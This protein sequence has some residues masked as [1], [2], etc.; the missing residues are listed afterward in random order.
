MVKSLPASAGDVRD[1]PGLIP[2]FRRFPKGE[3]GSPLLYSLENPMDR[4]A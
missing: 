2:G 4:G 3:H 1:T